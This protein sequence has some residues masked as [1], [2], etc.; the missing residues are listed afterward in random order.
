MNFEVRT[1][2]DQVIEK[3]RRLPGGIGPIGQQ[4]SKC[5]HGLGPALLPRHTIVPRRREKT[6][7]YVGFWQILLQ[8][9]FWGGELKFLEPLM[10]LTGGDVRDHIVSP[11]IDHGPPLWR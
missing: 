7:R 9:S 5:L 1:G 4:F 2:V 8:K 10:R 11:K 3:Q 6:S